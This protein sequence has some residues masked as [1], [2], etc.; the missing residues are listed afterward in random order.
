MKNKDDN[1]NDKSELKD[2]PMPQRSF[3]YNNWELLCGPLYLLWLP[4]FLCLFAGVPSVVVWLFLF[5]IFICSILQAINIH[6]ALNNNDKPLAI[7]MFL[8]Q[9]IGMIIAVLPI[10]GNV[11]YS[12]RYMVQH[13]IFTPFP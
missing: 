9:I 11:D 13:D 10:L 5:Y 8:L 2:Y 6:H 12:I 1:R 3:L 7:K 4:I